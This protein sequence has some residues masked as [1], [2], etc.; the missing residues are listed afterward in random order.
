MKA[1]KLKAKS[2]AKKRL[3]AIGGSACGNVSIMA[4]AESW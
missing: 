3:K 2:E 1:I 4:S